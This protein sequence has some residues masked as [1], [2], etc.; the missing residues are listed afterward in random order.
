M[1]HSILIATKQTF[2]LDAV[3]SCEI[4]L[5][6]VESCIK[7]KL[8]QNM[9]LFCPENDWGIPPSHKGFFSLVFKK[10]LLTVL[11]KKR[12]PLWYKQWIL[13]IVL[14]FYAYFS[15]TS[16]SFF[17]VKMSIFFPLCSRHKMAVKNTIE[18]L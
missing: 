11:L 3:T 1:F 2:F 10:N 7:F 4:V 8:V 14:Y 5:V 16:L 9:W 18:L 6:L 17:I 13:P 15:F 12:S